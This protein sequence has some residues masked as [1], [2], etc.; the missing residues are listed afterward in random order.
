MKDT[1]TREVTEPSGTHRPL[2]PAVLHFVLHF[3]LHFPYELKFESVFTSRLQWE[4]LLHLYTTL[5]QDTLIVLL[6]CVQNSHYFQV[7]VCGVCRYVSVSVSL[8]L[9][10]RL[11]ESVNVCEWVCVGVCQEKSDVKVCVKVWC[12]DKVCMLSGVYPPHTTSIVRTTPTYWPCTPIPIHHT[13]THTH[14]QT[15]TYTHRHTPTHTATQ[16]HTYRHTLSTT[17]NLSH[18]VC[19]YSGIRWTFYPHHL[20]PPDTWSRS[21]YT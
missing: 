5:T 6:E 15:H 16:R 18:T 17:Q 9:I 3:L 10:E 8:C 4:S 13:H 2:I 21:T 11:C 7:C 19:M 14:T 12:I 1:M 20:L